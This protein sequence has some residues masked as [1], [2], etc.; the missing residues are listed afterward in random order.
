MEH[1]IELRADL[2]NV[3]S[4]VSK[5]MAFSFSQLRLRSALS[6]LISFS[7]SAALS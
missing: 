7:L 6:S 3:A 1:A 2:E 4:D 5:Y